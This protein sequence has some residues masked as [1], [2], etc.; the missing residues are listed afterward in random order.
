MKIRAAD[1]SVSWTF[2]NRVGVCNGSSHILMYSPLAK[3]ICASMQRTSLRVCGQSCGQTFRNHNYVVNEFDT[4]FH[5]GL[6]LWTGNIFR[7]ICDRYLDRKTA[8]CK[9]E[10]TFE[11]PEPRHRSRGFA[12]ILWNRLDGHFSPRLPLP[13]QGH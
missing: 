8:S 1:T 4:C 5:E 7:R 12:M 10:A 6:M 3:I 13:R 9:C 11:Q 2:H